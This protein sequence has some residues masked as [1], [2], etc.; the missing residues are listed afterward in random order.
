MGL[1]GSIT[2]NENGYRCYSS[3]DI[4]WIEFLTQLKATGMSIT[5]MQEIAELRRQ[6]DPTLTA[7]RIL[8]EE[9]YEEVQKNMLEL[10][11]NLHL[12][13]DKIVIYKGMEKNYTQKQQSD[14]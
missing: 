3:A 2:R 4:T 5:K 8:L 6:G 7:R 11:N 12:L 9:H 14:K 1:L 13:A 10:Q